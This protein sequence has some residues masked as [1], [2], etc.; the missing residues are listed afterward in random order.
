MPKPLLTS[1]KMDRTVLAGDVHTVISTMQALLRGEEIYF[2][3]TKVCGESSSDQG[4]FAQAG[5]WSEDY[6][7]KTLMRYPVQR[8]LPWHRIE[9][10]YKFKISVL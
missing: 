10:Q 8:H 1:V 6:L 4:F 2:D 3:Q 5:A 9:V 7:Y